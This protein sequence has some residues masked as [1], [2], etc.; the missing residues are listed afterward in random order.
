M[1]E[2]LADYIPEWML[3][4]AAFGFLIGDAFG[5]AHRHRKCLQQANNALRERLEQAAPDAK[6][7]QQA[8][9]E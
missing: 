3:L 5:D 1:I 4:S 8:L 7:I 9:K 2:H 6:P